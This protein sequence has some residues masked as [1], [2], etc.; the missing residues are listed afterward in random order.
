MQRPNQRTSQPGRRRRLRV[1]LAVTVLSLPIA[2]IGCGPGPEVRVGGGELLTVGARRGAPSPARFRSA[3]SLIRRAARAYAA[4]VYDRR[5]PVLP[6]EAGSV[7]SALSAAARRVPPARHGRRAELR[8][9]RLVP[10]G[11]DRMAATATIGD[12]TF[13]SFTVGFELGWRRGWRLVGIS[14]PD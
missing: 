10:I 4:G 2:T 14:L 6:R 8:G 9:L 1:A 5:A 12:R 13:P 3:W 11:V 7:A